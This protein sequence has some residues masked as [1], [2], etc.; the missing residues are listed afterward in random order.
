MLFL[1][2]NPT[3]TASVNVFQCGT[4]RFLLYVK[5]SCAV[6]LYLLKGSLSKIK[7]ITKGT[8]PTKELIHKK[9]PIAKWN[10]FQNRTLPKKEPIPKRNLSQKGIHPKKKF[11][12]KNNPHQKETYSKKKPLPK[13]NLCQMQYD[14]FFTYLTLYILF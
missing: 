13:R 14:C 6:F 3:P 8:C 10:L 4:Y 5:L 12:S 11:I 7:P 1:I 2:L 9:E